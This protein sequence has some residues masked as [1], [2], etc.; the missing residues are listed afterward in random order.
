MIPNRLTQIVNFLMKYD[1]NLSRR[2]RDGRI[3][4]AFNEDE[5]F[6]IINGNFAVSRPEM[7]D[8]IDFG[9]EENGKFY[10]VNIKVTTTETTDNLNCKLGIYYVLTGQMPPFGN[11]IVWDKYFSSLRQNL[12]QNNS[13]YYFLIINKNDFGDVFATSLKCLQSITPNG[14]NL[15]FQARW[16]S[17][18][19]FQNRTFEKA[20]DFILGTFARSLKLRADA[21]FYFINY[22]SEYENA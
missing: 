1:F 11:E 12:R 16:D 8:W 4:S 13:D 18:R 14:N 15:P 20:K 7:R 2:T 9:F 17:N 19:S 3:N 6:N 10:P 22:F 5:I 21:Y